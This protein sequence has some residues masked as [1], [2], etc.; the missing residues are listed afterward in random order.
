MEDILEKLD[1][2]P[3]KDSGRNIVKKPKPKFEPLSLTFPAEKSIPETVADLFVTISREFNDRGFTLISSR[4]GNFLGPWELET[5]ECDNIV[6]TVNVC[7]MFIHGELKQDSPWNHDD[8]RY[9]ITEMVRYF[10][11]DP[12]SWVLT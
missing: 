4:T 12:I 2:K 1:R 8:V 11:E 9:L 6:I 5:W 3:I 10:T 7:T